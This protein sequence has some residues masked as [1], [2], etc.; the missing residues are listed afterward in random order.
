MYKL[1]TAQCEKAEFTAKD[2]TLAWKMASLVKKIVK[3][4]TGKNAF[5]ID[6]TND[7]P[8][9]KMRKMFK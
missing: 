5:N 3:L 4:K 8:D 7:I 2:Y 1:R 6:N 9:I